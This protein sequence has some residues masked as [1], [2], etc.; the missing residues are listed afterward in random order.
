[1]ED[2][3]RIIRRHGTST[4]NWSEEL[5]SSTA[6]PFFSQKSPQHWLQDVAREYE[7]DNSH[8]GRVIS[9]HPAAFPLPKTNI[10]VP[11]KKCP[12]SFFC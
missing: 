9:S 7:M 12:E 5:Q 1:M 10:E 3:P 4:K 8:G 2:M 11:H 6:S